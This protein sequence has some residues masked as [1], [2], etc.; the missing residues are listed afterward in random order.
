MLT[1]DYLLKTCKTKSKYATLS[2]SWEIKKTDDHTEDGAMPFSCEKTSIFD[3]SRLRF[4]MERS[5]K[6]Q[7][8]D[9]FYKER[10]SRCD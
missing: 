8:V 2:I 7:L 5:L 9:L 1:K 3:L 4:N 6:R 10:T